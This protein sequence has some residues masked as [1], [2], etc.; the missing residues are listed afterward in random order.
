MIYVR[1]R[2]AAPPTPEPEPE[3]I[4]EPEPA[5]P[6]TVY[7]SIGNSDDKLTQAQWS[8]YQAGLL[9]LAEWWASQIHGVW[10]SEPKS[11]YQNMC[12]CAEID[13]RAVDD[14]R[15]H[16]RNLARKFNQDSVAWAE[17]KETLFL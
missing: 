16:L 10:F 1:E 14:L 17:V 6:S 3:E 15:E 8:E 2:D 4:V 11:P 7:I 12:V 13:E 9:A 5:P